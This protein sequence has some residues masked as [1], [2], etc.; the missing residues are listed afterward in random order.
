MRAG[1]GSMEKIHR[2][3]EDII[4][5]RGMFGRSTWF[6][7]RDLSLIWIVSHMA[8]IVRRGYY[9]LEFL[10]IL[11]AATVLYQVLV[12]STNENEEGG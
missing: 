5:M 7:P 11:R 4:L 9:Y 3:S 6:S 8:S 1:T 2:W 12:K 10:V